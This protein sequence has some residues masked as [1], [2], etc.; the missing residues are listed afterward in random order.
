MFDK[1]MQNMSLAIRLLICKSSPTRFVLMS[2]NNEWLGNKFS[3]SSIQIIKK[4]VIDI[5]VV[6]AWL[7]IIGVLYK[8]CY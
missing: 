3:C 8:I 4:E 5:K 7:I 2:K 1:K 6:S